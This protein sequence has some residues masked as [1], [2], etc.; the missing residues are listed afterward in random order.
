MSFCTPKTTPIK[1]T[2][3]PNKMINSDDMAPNSKL[4]NIACRKIFSLTT[5]GVNDA[6]IRMV[7]E[8]DSIGKIVDDKNNNNADTVIEA[9]TYVSSDLKRYPII[10]PDKMNIVVIKNNIRTVVPKT[11][12]TFVSK[13]MADVTKKISNWIAITTNAVK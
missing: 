6:N 13:K 4:K 1:T 2:M 3:Y 12:I 8:I 9:N 7:S 5:N 10:I 11:E